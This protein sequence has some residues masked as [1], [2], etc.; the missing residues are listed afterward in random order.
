MMTLSQKLGVPVE[1]P[2]V[3]LLGND[4]PIVS[5]YEDARCSIGCPKHIGCT[6]V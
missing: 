4:D 3:A 6:M 5:R 2:E 1:F